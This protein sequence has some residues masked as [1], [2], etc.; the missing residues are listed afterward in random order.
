LDTELRVRT[1]GGGVFKHLLADCRRDQ[2]LQRIAICRILL[3][4]RL[5]TLK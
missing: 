1:Y 4:L 3:Q 2:I 5:H